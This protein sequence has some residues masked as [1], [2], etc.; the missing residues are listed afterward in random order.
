MH[1][2]GRTAHRAARPEPSA[3]VR[4]A[5]EQSLSIMTATTEFDLLA[6]T[7]AAAAA[8]TGADVAAA[9]PFKAESKAEQKGR[10]A[11]RLPAGNPAIP[12][13]GEPRL[14]SRLARAAAQRLA[15]GDLGPAGPTP[16]FSGI[17]LPSAVTALFGESLIVIASREADRLGPDAA[18]LLELVLDQARAGRERLRELA[19]L[20]RRAECDPLTGL[21]HQRPFEDRLRASQP[22]RTAVLALDVD[23]FKWINDQFGHEAGD[24]AL[25]NLAS[26]LQRA[27]PSSG[28]LYRIGGD[29][30]AVVID[31]ADETKIAEVAERLL[32]AARAAG[33]PIS[34]GAA[35]RQPDETGRQTLHRA[36][37]ALYRAKQA[38]R[39]T[40]RLA[41]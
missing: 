32:A 7:L 35:V 27:L 23:R 28:D 19:Q 40:A 37:R 3:S 15:G 29:E 5:L 17:G 30:F 38:G 20:A 21:R 8:V 24:A 22:G 39:D 16:A 25:V 6:R 33:H 10:P 11:P 12:R 41:A 13:Q 9:V 18:L 1:V 26:A 31:A 14:A 4:Q 2:I 34:I 36:D